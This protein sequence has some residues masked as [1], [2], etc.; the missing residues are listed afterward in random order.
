MNNVK[1]EIRNILIGIANGGENSFICY[2]DL[3]KRIT[4]VDLTE[5]STEL[6]GLLGE[7]SEQEV[8]NNRAM[9]SVVVGSKNND[10]KPGHGFFQLAE[11]LGRKQKNEDE[12]FFWLK[13]LNLVRDIYKE[14]PPGANKDIKSSECQFWVEQYW[15]SRNRDFSKLYIWFNDKKQAKNNAVRTG[16]RILFYE[17]KNHPA[18]RQRG[19]KTVFASG[20]VLDDVIMIPIE[21]Q[22][23]GGKRWVLKRLV[24]PEYVLDP[25]QGITLLTVKKLLGMKGWPQTGFQIVNPQGFEQIEAELRKKQEQDNQERVNNSNKTPFQEKN[26]TQFQSLSREYNE[27]NRLLALEKAANAHK[28]LLNKLNQVICNHKYDTSE[29]NKVDLFASINDTTW[30]FEIKSTND[31]NFLSQVRHGVAQLYEYRFLFSTRDRA[32]NLCLIVQTPPPTELNW[33]GEYLQTLNIFFCWPV[34]TGFHSAYGAQL[35]FLIT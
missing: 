8:R 31:T 30:I 25:K 24:R 10:N 9:L 21:E 4:S 29:N 13:E 28:D 2:S 12:D 11:R 23:R 32:S 7:I 20:T 22:L 14:I 16:D 3:A 18:E 35:D 5:R 15:P 34:P 26:A 1:D 19:N 33:I 27:S 6:W 17:T